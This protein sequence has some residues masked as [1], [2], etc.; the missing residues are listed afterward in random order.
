MQQLKRHS[1]NYNTTHKNTWL[2]VVALFIT[3]CLNV[4]S[5][6]TRPSD[7]FTMLNCV[8]ATSFYADVYR[9]SLSGLA[10]ISHRNLDIGEK[11]N[12]D[13]WQRYKRTRVA[14]AVGRASLGNDATSA[15]AGRLRRHVTVVHSHRYND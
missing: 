11:L 3:G 7:V 9:A 12:G 13:L 2:N 1:L 10:A 8:M 6:A 15:A 5:Q 4:I 14:A